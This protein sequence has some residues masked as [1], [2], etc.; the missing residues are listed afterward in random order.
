MS[1]VINHDTYASI[2]VITGSAKWYM[3]GKIRTVE[4]DQAPLLT[5]TYHYVALFGFSI[6][7]QIVNI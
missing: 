2:A 5:I 4:V 1:R 6:I 3:V 7:S